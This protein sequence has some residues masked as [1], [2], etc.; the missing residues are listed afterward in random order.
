MQLSCSQKPGNSSSTSRN[1]TWK[2]FLDFYRKLVYHGKKT[3][4]QTVQ[5]KRSLVRKSE[6]EVPKEVARSRKTKESMRRLTQQLTRDIPFHYCIPKTILVTKERLIFLPFHRRMIR[7][8]IS[9][10]FWNL[11]SRHGKYHQSHRRNNERKKNSK[12]SQE[13]Q[14]TFPSRFTSDSS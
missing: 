9:D 3:Q 14:N 10:Y 2:V 8:I 12:S 4:K 6:N 11:K 5:K 1:K 13:L 7:G